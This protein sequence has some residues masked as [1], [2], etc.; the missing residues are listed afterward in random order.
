MADNREHMVKIKAGE[1][2]G[3]PPA[4]AWE[5][6]TPCSE[7]APPEGEEG[8]GHRGTWAEAGRGP[9]GTAPVADR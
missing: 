5:G 6:L 9:G 3:S 7:D 2:T 8:G 4:Y 1:F